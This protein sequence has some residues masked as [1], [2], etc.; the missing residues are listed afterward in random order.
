MR[1]VAAALACLALL[2][3]PAASATTT[4]GIDHSD[5]WWNAAESGWGIHVTQQGD[6]LFAVL[7]VYDD[8]QRPRFFVASSMARVAK[9]PRLDRGRL[10]HRP[11]GRE[12]ATQHGKT[13]ALDQRIAART[14]D[15]LVV[16][17]SARKILAQRLPVHRH[18][19]AIDEIGD[20]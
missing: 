13:V 8:Q 15:V 5:L 18:R 1:I 7:F 3:A 11:I 9:E 4:S 10:D 12:I 14:D 17:G 2:L 6:V 19:I 20:P 16:D